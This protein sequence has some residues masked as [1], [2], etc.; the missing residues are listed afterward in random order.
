MQ[1]G[2]RA[3]SL[4]ITGRNPSS[5]GFLVGIDRIRLSPKVE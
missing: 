3:V 2:P 1:Q 5:T 4:K